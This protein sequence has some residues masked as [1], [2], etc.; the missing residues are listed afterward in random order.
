V[1]TG[2]LG[3]LFVDAAAARPEA[4]AVITDDRAVSYGE[5][6][7]R[8][9]GV[10][11]ALSEAAAG[12]PM[13]VAI[14]AQNGLDYVVSYWG[15]LLAGCT[16]V[17][18]NPGLGEAELRAQLEHAG[19]RIVV[20]ER[21]A[22]RRLGGPGAGAGDFAAI[23]LDRT[24]PELASCIS[25]VLGGG[26][27]A[28]AAPPAPVAEDAVASIVYTS[29]TTGRPR[30]VCLTHRNLSWTAGA[31]AH[32][33]G[34]AGED[35]DERLLGTLPLFYTY[36]KSVLHLATWLRAPVVFT[37][38]LPS[39]ANLMRTIAE[40]DI[41]HLSL[42]PFQATLLLEEP[43]F[44]G[45]RLGSLRRITIAGGAL[46]QGSLA[47]LLR[48]FP[49]RVVPMYGLTEASTRVTCM[50]AAET[51]R[52]PASC[53]RP[54]SGVELRIVGEDG[55]PRA[56]GAT[57]EIQVRG[58]NIMLGYFRDRDATAAALADGWLRT[59]DLGSLDAGGY[60]SISG[61]LKGLIKVMGESVSAESIEE[62]IAT[63]PG[64]REVAVRGVPHPRMGEAI[65]AFVVRRAGAAPS[66]D[67]I[68]RLCGRELGRVRVPAYVRFLAALPRTSSGKVRRHLLAL[69]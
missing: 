20:G 22:L 17:E 41:T 24:P 64:V 29:G 15:I 35:R 7:R 27:L 11:G 30:G 59:G 68:R 60:L 39:P 31:I 58:P 21:G 12:G 51:A 56:G 19:P 55:R 23:A 32:S 67:E 33:F 3:D 43:D 42:V 66:V 38:R 9:A 36:G 65:A 46:S 40:R 2:S 48:R 50:P 13:R 1:T 53:G 10:A 8:V 5:L 63:H 61:R 69:D 49:G 57:G 44:S 4:A 34:L 45:E 52:R 6:W 26:G 14:L 16:T 25:A 47:E 28:R 37:R 62:V 18:L 54:L